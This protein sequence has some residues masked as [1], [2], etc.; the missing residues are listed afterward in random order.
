MLSLRFDMDLPSR[1]AL[2]VWVPFAVLGAA[3]AY[4]GVR[5]NDIPA[6]W[7]THWDVA[8]RANGWA[9]HDAVGVFGPL[10]MGAVVLAFVQAIAAL[11]TRQQSAAFAV[12]GVRE[13][14]IV[15]VRTIA[16]ALSLVFAFLAIDL[17]LG[18][19]LSHG[20]LTGLL[21]AV[22]GAGFAVG[23]VRMAAAL[24]AARSSGHA[25][26]VEGWHSF[27]YSNARDRRLWVPKLS[28]LG[29]TV[30]FANPWSWLVMALLVGVPMA[31]AIAGAIGSR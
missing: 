20:V 16:V 26:A 14:T 5:W 10:V 8:G 9:R 17:P 11:T 21:L 15:F 25:A 2:P 28:G 6:A 13:A 27:Y 19:R 23:A 24:A 30:N 18:P 1:R 4:L 3:A 29:W 31:W 22:M 12:G 7:T